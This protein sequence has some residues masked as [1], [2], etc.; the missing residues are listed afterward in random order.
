M[1]EEGLAVVMAGVVPLELVLVE[2]W[3]EALEAGSVV[4]LA[5]V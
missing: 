3:D 4:A 5:M 1:W 2:A